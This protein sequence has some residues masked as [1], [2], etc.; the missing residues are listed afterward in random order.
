MCEGVSSLAS[1]GLSFSVK[2]GIT[3]TSETLCDRDYDLM[4]VSPFLSCVG[5]WLKT[6]GVHNS[7]WSYCILAPQ[8]GAQESLALKQV[9]LSCVNPRMA[10]SDR[11][12][13]EDVW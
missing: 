2:S 11:A 13:P 4:V 8:R 12:W 1:L 5:Q 10:E 3:V 9:F 7:G 6:Q